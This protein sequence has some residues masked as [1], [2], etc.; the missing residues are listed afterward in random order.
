MS[1]ILHFLLP[2]VCLVC[3]TGIPRGQRKYCTLCRLPEQILDISPRCQIC[4]DQIQSFTNQKICQPC[5]LNRPIYNRLR[6]LW[7]YEKNVSDFIR[8][9]K[10]YPSRNLCIHAG[11]NLAKFYNYF[12]DY[13]EFDGVVSMPCS[14]KSY[15]KRGFN[16]VD[17]IVNQ[18]GL[19]IL[20]QVLHSDRYNS[21]TKLKKL[22]REKNVYNK[23]KANS[24]VA[25]N[26]RILL[27]DDV[28][29]TG[30]TANSAA[31][32]LYQAGARSVDIL[33]L[34]KTKLIA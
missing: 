31:K 15:H 21:Q 27:I 30:A 23:F 7:Y 9:M 2:Q 26:Q 29:T 17:L 28:Y 25:K 3:G 6:F 16:H 1:L 18:L 12:F 13:N 10:Y 11:L 14:E 19:K 32:A 22:A 4:F 24:S 8:T 34:A 33:T 5:Q 20:P